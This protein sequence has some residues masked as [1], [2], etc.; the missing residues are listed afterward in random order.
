M[1]DLGLREMA[2]VEGLILP[3]VFAKREGRH[4]LGHLVTKVKRMRGIDVVAA[5]LG[6]LSKQEEGIAGGDME[7][8]PHHVHLPTLGENAEV[9]IA[10]RGGKPIK[11]GG[12]GEK[13]DQLEVFVPDRMA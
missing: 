5:R 2:P 12:M 3:I 7:P 9:G 4:G 13:M 1:G 10:N 11:F 6:Q 8:G